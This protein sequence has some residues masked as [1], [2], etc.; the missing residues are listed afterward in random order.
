[1]S[2]GLSTDGND[3]EK[4]EPLMALE[5]DGQRA[6]PREGEQNPGTHRK[7]GL[8][9]KKGHFFH[10]TTEKERGCKCQHGDKFG[11]GSMREF[12]S[13]GFSFLHKIGKDMV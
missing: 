6:D 5:E 3:P 1:M 13:D 8:R 12:P 10:H 4:R 7:S 2:S 11:G 9:S